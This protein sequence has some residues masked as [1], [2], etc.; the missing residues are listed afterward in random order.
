[1]GK[2]EELKMVVSKYCKVDTVQRHMAD[3]RKLHGTEECLR[4]SLLCLLHGSGGKGCS[5]SPGLTNVCQQDEV[6]LSFG[7]SSYLKR[8]LPQRSGDH[9]SQVAPLW[10]LAACSGRALT[11]QATLP[12]CAQRHSSDTDPRRSPATLENTL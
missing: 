1:M 5:G 7:C 4:L 6:S 2:K 9:C 12:A 10:P 3:P 8:K 11:Q